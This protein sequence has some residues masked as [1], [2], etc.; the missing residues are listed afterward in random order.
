MIELGVFNQ[1][2]YLEEQGVRLI[3]TESRSIRQEGKFDEYGDILKEEDAKI[4]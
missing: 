4:D 3:R 2:G 1:G